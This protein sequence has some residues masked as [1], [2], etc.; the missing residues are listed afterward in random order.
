MFG[1]SGKHLVILVSKR[2]IP[3]AGSSD[4]SPGK[5]SVARL[6]PSC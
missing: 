1:E 3:I 4:V 2:K 5:P 6:N